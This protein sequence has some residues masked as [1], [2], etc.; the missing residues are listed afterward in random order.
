MAVVTQLYLQCYQMFQPVN[1]CAKKNKVSIMIK[2]GIRPRRCAFLHTTF[3][4]K[5]NVHFTA[6]TH[7]ECNNKLHKNTQPSCK[8]TL[9]RGQTGRHNYETHTKIK[10]HKLL[11][12]RR[13]TQDAHTATRADRYNVVLHPP[14][15]Q[16]P[17]TSPSHQP[18][19]RHDRRKS[20]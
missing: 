13:E 2:R 12:A 3:H 15:G 19:G 17:K 16:D 11:P 14:T 5:A 6:V 7:S 18:P 1:T 8:F 20:S 4:R 10:P 9:R